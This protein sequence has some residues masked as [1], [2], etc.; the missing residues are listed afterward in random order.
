MSYD[1]S[2]EEQAS[3]SQVG[4]T[5]VARSSALSSRIDTGPLPTILLQTATIDHRPLV[6]RIHL[7]MRANRSDFMTLRIYLIQ[8]EKP[9]DF[10]WD[11]K[12]RSGK[13]HTM[14]GT[15]ALGAMILGS[16]AGL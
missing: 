5:K 6:N 7:T 13:S 10:L 2:T 9:K 14:T 4:R 11:W 1:Y 12:G 8:G 15:G 16:L 3:S